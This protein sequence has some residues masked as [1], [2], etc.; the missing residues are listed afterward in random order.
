MGCL[1]IA[2]NFGHQRHLRTVQVF[3]MSAA[4]TLFEIFQLSEHIPVTHALE[5]GGIGCLHAPPISAAAIGAIILPK[6]S[7]SCVPRAPFL[8]D[9]SCR[10][11]YQSPCPLNFGAF[12]AGSPCA[13]MP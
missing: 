2:Q 7:F 1:V 11:R 10:F 12:A 13:C 8:K 6:T 3:W 5:P 4:D 9:F